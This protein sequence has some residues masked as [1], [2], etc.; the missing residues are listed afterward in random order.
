M[1]THSQSETQAAQRFFQFVR[2]PA[3]TRDGSRAY[4]R[5]QKITEMMEF[6]LRS[7]PTGLVVSLGCSHRNQFPYPY[8]AY[9]YLHQVRIVTCLMIA[10]AIQKTGLGLG[11]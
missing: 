7:G 4:V 9:P 10:N 8:L 6:A 2:Y 3:N 11:R 1:V 5:L